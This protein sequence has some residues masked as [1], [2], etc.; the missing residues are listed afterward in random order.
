MCTPSPLPAVPLGRHDDRPPS[1]NA[2]TNVQ[3]LLHPSMDNP[4]MTHTLEQKVSRAKLRSRGE[5]SFDGYSPP[6][7]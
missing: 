5:N 4:A 1:N 6:I 7:K 3:Q 2:P